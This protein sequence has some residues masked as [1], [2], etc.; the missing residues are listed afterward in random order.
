MNSIEQEVKTEI[1]PA[2]FFEKLEVW[3]TLPLP[4][5]IAEK[6]FDESDCDCGKKHFPTRLNPFTGAKFYQDH[7][8]E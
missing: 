2:T 4:Q 5:S 3:T 6:L 1:R 8:E 7:H